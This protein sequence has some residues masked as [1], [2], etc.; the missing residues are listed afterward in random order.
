MGPSSP[1]VG[2]HGDGALDPEAVADDRTLAPSAARVRRA[3]RAGLRPRSAWLLP[4]AAC[5][6]VALALRGGLASEAPAWIRPG[7][8]APEAWLERVSLVLVVGWLAMGGLVL[9]VAALARRLG[10]VSAADGQRLRPAPERPAW[11]QRGGLGL[12]L[13]LVLLV[14]LRGV[15]AG[16]AR[17]VD[18]SEAGLTALWSGWAAT[19]GGGLAI[20]LLVAALVDLLIDRRER[21]ARLFLHPQQQRDEARHAGGRAR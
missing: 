5:G 16:A 11:I 9:G 13:A 15:L 7:A 2:A 19:L 6:L 1:R 12:V 21:V 8:I 14:A 10:P 17:S 18:A 20:G 4:A 3:W